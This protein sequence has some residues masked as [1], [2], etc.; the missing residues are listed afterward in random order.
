M[1]HGKPAYELSDKLKQSLLLKKL[2]KE[3]RVLKEI[4]LDLAPSHY[5]KYF[6]ESGEE[7]KDD[8]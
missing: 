7:G 8:A 3:V 6:K 5:Y 2:E 1:N 4:L